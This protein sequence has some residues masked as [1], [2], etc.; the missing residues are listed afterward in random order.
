ML[1][2]APNSPQFTIIDVNDAY[3]TAVMK[4]RDDL[5]GR[6]LFEALPDN[7]D[8][9]SATG[10]ANLQASIERAIATGKPDRMPVQKYGIAGT[11][12][13]EERWWDPVNSP[14][15]DVSGAVSAVIHHVADATER[16]RT[17]A[18]LWTHAARQT[19]RLALEERLRSLDEPTEI[20]NAA[21]G[22]LGQHLGASRVGYGEV[23]PDDATVVLHS[24]YADGVELLAGAFPLDSFGPGTIARHHRGESVVCD[25]VVAEAKHALAIWAAIDTRAFVSVPLVRDGR[26][27]ASLYVNHRMP[28]R[29]SNEE[30]A[31]IEEV[32]ARTWAAVE[33]ARA[34]TAQRGSE[35]RMRFALKAGR[36]GAWDL[37]LATGELTTSE[38]CRA[39]FG[40]DPEAPFTYAE[41]RNE[42]HPDDKERMVAAV[43]HSVASGE[44]YD[45]DYRAITPEGEVRW[46]QIRARPFYA[47]DGTPSRMSGVSMDVT[48][49]HAS[50]ERLHESEAR[51][52]TLFDIIDEGFCILE[53][54]DGPRG[55][56][57]DYVHIEANA[58]YSANAGIPDIVGKRLREVVLAEEADSWVEQFCSVL[59]TGDAIRF[60]QELIATGRH[61]ELAAFRVE[62]KSRRQ[63]AVLFTDTTKR[64]IAEQRLR[65]LN[66]TLEVRVNLAIAERDRAWNNARDLLLVV[67]IDGVFRAVNP[68]WRTI[69]GWGENELVGGS[70]LDLIHPDD[71]P[72]S[73][74][75]LTTASRGELPTYDNRYRHKDGSYRTISW[76]AAPEG[77]L[78]YAS[79]RDVTV[80]RARE[81]ELAQAQEVLRQSQKMEAMGQ[82]TGGVAHDFNNLLTPIVGSLDMLQRRGL[83]NER[84]QRLIGGAMQSAERAKTLVQRLLAFA[85][86][87]PL[88]AVAVDV[89]VLVNG[90]AGLI[91]ST[92]GPNI[93]VLVELADDLPPANADP[94]QL[95][96]AILNLGVNA[97][98]AMPN[99][100]TLTIAG[101]RESL[102]AGNGRGFKPGHYVRLSVSDTGIGMDEATLARAIEPFF[103]TKGI[104]KGTGLGL[105]MV[106]GLSAQLGG[107]LTIASEP[108]Q[109]TT[110]SLWLPLGFGPLVTEDSPTAT[111]AKHAR[112]RALLVDDEELV[113]MSTADMLNDLGYEVVEASSAEDALKLVS[114]GVQA[115]VLVTDHLMPGM[116]GAELA[117]AVRAVK[118]GLPI[119]IVSGYAEVDGIAPDL[120]RLTKPFRNAELAERLAELQPAGAA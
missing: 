73:Q 17:D 111:S 55:P 78:I 33:R 89:G 50:D 9:P 7:P 3:L 83:G 87:Q 97:R 114:E 47:P 14:V 36:L 77:D 90:M 4:T 41:L 98:D 70:F 18:A 30:V 100:G 104:G 32:A 25:D 12:G 115:D 39:N 29:W 74:G 15:L 59:E 61:L 20:M 103:S 6:A 85:R 93:D 23:Q 92:L 26:F 22:V 72:S 63:V 65:E 108:G 81:A 46:V 107:G 118:P 5:V 52:R 11:V 35:A 99:G 60:E 54:I 48:E 95:E 94:N 66:D 58:A 10:V 86:R 44:D 109:G 101:A 67:G 24:C 82:L 45:I 27:T 112:G 69:L 120:P 37:D 19:F 84:E 75:A 2:V 119:L 56:L 1:I 8:D 79:G 88:Q 43:E 57:S 91:G 96:M 106:H 31:L 40:R 28:H 71:H 51:Y 53:F 64:K 117:R 49:R 13:F 110:I 42:V 105:S 21:V 113:R 116:S 62:P 102:K 34:E 80:E 68:A 38:T 16:V 76:V